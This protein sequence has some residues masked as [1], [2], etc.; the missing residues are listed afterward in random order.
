M[1]RRLGWYALIARPGRVW[2]WKQ[3]WTWDG[4]PACNRP[5]ALRRN[6]RENAR[7]C[8][9]PRD[10]SAHV[11]ASHVGHGHRQFAKIL[12]GDSVESLKK[13]E[14]PVDIF[15]HDSDTRQLMNGPSSW[16]SSRDARRFAHE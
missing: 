12:I 1:G 6:E 2:L 10:N 7:E 11:W 13:S 14:Q 16:P 4:H 8:S 15:I 5:P 9:T 3:A